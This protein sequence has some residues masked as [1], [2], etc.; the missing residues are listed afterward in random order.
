MPRA[1]QDYDTATLASNTGLSPS[2]A[3]LSKVLFSQTSSDNSLLLPR[4]RLNGYGL[5]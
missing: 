3:T 4:S 2:M 1:T 5:G